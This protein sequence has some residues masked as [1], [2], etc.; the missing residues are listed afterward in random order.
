MDIEE[1]AWLKA[2]KYRQTVLLAL[3]G[4]PRTPKDIAEDTGYYLSH[5]SKTLSDLEEH[6]LVECLTPDRRKGRLY[7]ATDQGSELAEELKS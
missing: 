5:V 7:A 6:G 3:L 4:T 1:F 2:S